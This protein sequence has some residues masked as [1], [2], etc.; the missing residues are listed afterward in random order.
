MMVFDM[1]NVDIG[2]FNI[3]AIEMRLFFRNNKS[4]ENIYRYE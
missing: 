2:E 1:R 3:E 4:F